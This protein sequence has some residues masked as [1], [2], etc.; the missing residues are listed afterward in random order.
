MLAG[1]LLPILHCAFLLTGIATTMMGVLLPMV[2]LRWSIT[3]A[4][5]G[6]LF[7]AQFAAQFAGSLAY[8]GISRRLGNHRTVVLGLLIITAGVLGVAVSYWP[9]PLAFVA[10]YGLGL[11]LAL[12][13]TNLLVAE[14]SPASRASA[15]NLLN[16][17]WTLGAVTA[18]PLFVYLGQRLHVSLSHLLA[19]FAGV[20]A[21]SAVLVFLCPSPSAAAEEM[22]QETEAPG[23]SIEIW[24]LTGVLLFLYVGVENGIPG[25]TGMFGLRHRML[26]ST[27]I[28]YALALYWGSLLLGR[29]A[30]SFLWPQAAPRLLISTSLITAALGAALIAAATGPAV[31]YAGLFLAGGG[32]AAVFP[33]VVSVFSPLATGRAK[34]AAGIMFASAGLGGA[35]IPP[36]IGI[37]STRGYGLRFGL[38][39]TAAV[40]VV[41]LM[42]ERR[43][44]SRQDRLQ[45]HHRHYRSAEA[46]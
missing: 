44:T 22:S 10:M 6:S 41:M 13:A 33:T 17:S 20:V 7:A 12:P 27:S 23:S 42:I 28:A 16:F 14:L 36:L 46:G 9:L 5:A 11:G 19:S 15:L 37:F 3:D 45:Q 24:L 43:I 1:L 8:G 29:L 34:A 35:V 38:W 25:W 21:C 31:L 39:L 18:P 26:T 4:Q 30:A 40:A 32:L 2:V